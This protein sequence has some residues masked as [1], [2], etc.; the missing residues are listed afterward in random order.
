MVTPVQWMSLH[1][2][3][4]LKGHMVSKYKQL[5]LTCA[6]LGA[7][8]SL[9]GFA[10][11]SAFSSTTSNTG[12]TFATGSVVLSDND[13]GSSMYSVS[14]AGPG[15]STVK[16]IKVTYTGSMAADVKLYTPTTLGAGAGYIDLTIEKGTGNPTFPGCTGFTSTA[17]I[18]SGTLGAFAGAKNSYTNG[19]SSYPAGQTEWDQNDVVV[20][21]FTLTVQD[22]NS[23]QSQTIAS[24][25]FTWEARNQ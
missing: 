15:I 4:R 7:A 23:A 17:T 12:N 11:F 25:D 20:Y 16:C 19:V 24:H 21:R 6:I 3:L 9:A 22:T 14:N 2:I 8:G 13:A 18:Y 5:L 10:T 1:P